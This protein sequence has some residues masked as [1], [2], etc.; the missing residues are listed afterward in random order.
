MAEIGI[1]RFPPYGFIAIERGFGGSLPASDPSDSEAGEG[2][3][4]DAFRVAKGKTE[5]GLRGLVFETGFLRLVTVLFSPGLGS[6][7][8][9][10]PQ[11]Q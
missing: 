7:A 3:A 11:L 6:P 4:S 8:G 9:W 1:R 5:W 10:L 2:E